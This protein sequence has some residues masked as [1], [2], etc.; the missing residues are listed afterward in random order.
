MLFPA[1]I[2]T[3]FKYRRELEQGHTKLCE[4]YV[5]MVEYRTLDFVDPT[6][7]VLLDSLNQH[8]VKPS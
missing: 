4:L 3:N 8:L 2:L 6:I 7:S 1:I 5:A